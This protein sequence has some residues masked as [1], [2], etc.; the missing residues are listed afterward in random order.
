MLCHMLDC[1]HNAFE[2]G[3]EYMIVIFFARVLYLLEQG[4]PMRIDQ[5]IN[6]FEFV[7]DII[8]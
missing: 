2:I 4:H 1:E 3:V 6:F 8:N 7:Y 5:D